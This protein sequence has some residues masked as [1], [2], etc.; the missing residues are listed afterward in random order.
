MTTTIIKA[1]TK[2]LLYAQHCAKPFIGIISLNPHRNLGGAY[3]YY[4]SHLPYKKTEAQ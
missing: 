4:Y 1:D 3:R 2:H